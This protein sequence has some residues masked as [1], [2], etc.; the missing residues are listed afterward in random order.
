MSDGET[1][2]DR[3]LAAFELFEF[4]VEMM[5]ATLRRRH[6]EASPEQIERMLDAWRPDPDLARDQE[7]YVA[8]VMAFA[9]STHDEVRARMKLGSSP[10]K[11]EWNRWEHEAAMTPDRVKAFYKQTTNYIYELAEWHL[12]V[13][14]KR[15]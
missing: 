10:L 5:A 7:E 8:D 14:G 13:P 6:P 4:G 11:D 2:K 1:A 12:F 15:D 3:L 9:H